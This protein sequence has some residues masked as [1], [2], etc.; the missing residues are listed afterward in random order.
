[1]GEHLVARLMTIPVV[2]AFKMV[3]IQ[4]HYRV[5]LMLLFASFRQRFRPLK[6]RAAVIDPRQRVVPCLPL[7]RVLQP[8]HVADH[9]ADHK[10]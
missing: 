3:K 7:E 8:V 2:N 9:P 4:L 10:P 6:Q 1:M 5:G